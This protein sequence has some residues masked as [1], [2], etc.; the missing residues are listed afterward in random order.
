MICHETRRLL[1]AY[2]DNELDLR[3]AL[4]LEEHSRTARAAAPTR[5]ACASCRRPR[6]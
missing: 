1:D 4:E 6:E 2:V 5:R 3:G